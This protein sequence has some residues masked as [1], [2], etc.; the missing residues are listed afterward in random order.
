K[1]PGLE[2]FSRQELK[3]RM[4]FAWGINTWTHPGTVEL[5]TEEEKTHSGSQCLIFSPNIPRKKEAHIF[6]RVSVESGKE[7]VFKVWARVDE[8]VFDKLS[9]PRIKLCVYEYRNGKFLPGGPH[10]SYLPLDKKWKEFSFEYTPREGVN[11]ACC[12]IAVIDCPVYI[13]DASFTLKEE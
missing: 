11:Q 2:K 9:P 5:V 8:K 6:Q 3:N 10:S 12:A 4:F 13:D 1:N 7:Y